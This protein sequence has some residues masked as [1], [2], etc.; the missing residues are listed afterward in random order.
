VETNDQKRGTKRLGDILV[1][2]GSLTVEALNR[3]IESQ[4]QNEKD[5]RLGEILLKDHLVPKS[6]IGHALEQTRGVPYV[7]CPP[8][9]VDQAIL[10]LLPESI[11]IRCCALPLEIKGRKLIVAMA[12]PQNLAFLDELR[13]RV[14][15]SISPRFSFRDDILEAIE[16]FYEPAPDYSQDTEES[17]ATS[18]GRD[19]EATAD[20]EFI[21]TDDNDEVSEV[22]KELRAGRQ[23]TPAVRF[24]TNIMIAAVEK[25]ASDIHVE[26]RETATIVRIRVDG[27]LRELMTIESEHHAS[28]VSRV[29]ILSNMDIS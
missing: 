9:T 21:A 13:F 4:K 22:Q 29:K 3:A 5:I 11:A 1:Q 15:M 10:D 24:L 23:R 26:P 28:L 18:F 20:V 12:E 7:E 27:I 8:A 17:L 14:G 25:G 2:R 6:E 16:R 19:D